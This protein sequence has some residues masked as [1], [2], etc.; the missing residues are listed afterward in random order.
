MTDRPPKKT[1]LMTEAERDAYHAEKM[2]KKK[3]AR[4][5]I[6]AAA[7]FALEPVGGGWP[8]SRRRRRA[9]PARRR[10]R[11]AGSGRA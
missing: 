11:G 1:E 8:R 7:V 3:E 2:K 9:R 10:S 6:L 4:N 5:K